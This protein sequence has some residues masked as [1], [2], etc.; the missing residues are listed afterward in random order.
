MGYSSN[1]NRYLEWAAFRLLI[2]N[3]KYDA[4]GAHYCEPAELD[5]MGEIPN[6]ALILL[7]LQIGIFRMSPHY[8]TIGLTRY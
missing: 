1:Y 6:A 7:V 8:I 5:E 3:R 4:I 2:L